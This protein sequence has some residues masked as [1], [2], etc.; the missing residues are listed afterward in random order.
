MAVVSIVLDHFPA[1]A[2]TP[3]GGKYEPSRVVVV[4]GKVQVW[5]IRNN[6]EPEVVYESSE[7]SMSG[8]RLAG[9]DIQTPDGIVKAIRAGGCGCGSKLKSF[10]P[11]DGATRTVERRD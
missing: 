3:D 8:N 4:D 1:I 11:Y 7:L 6:G 2:Y 5:F 10:D 9:F